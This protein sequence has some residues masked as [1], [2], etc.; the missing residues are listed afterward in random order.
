MRQLLLGPSLALAALATTLNPPEP[1]GW[2]QHEPERKK[3][4]PNRTKQAAAKKAR[5]RTKRA[6]AAP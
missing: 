1:T 4:N 3:P 2:R 5:K 6:G